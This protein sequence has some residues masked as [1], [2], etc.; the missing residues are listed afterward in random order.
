[1]LVLNRDE[2]NLSAKIDFAKVGLDMSKTKGGV[3]VRDLHAK[4]DIGVVKGAEWTAPVIGRHELG[5]AEADAAG[6]VK[7]WAA[8]IV[9]RHCTWVVRFL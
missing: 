9:W 3:R 5:D 8:A 6:R 4:K 2:E 1:M 7:V